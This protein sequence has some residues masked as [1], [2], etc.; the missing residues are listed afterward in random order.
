V[1][2]RDNAG[3][4]GAGEVPGGNA[5]QQTLEDARPL[6]MGRSIA[7]CNDVLNAIRK[8]FSSRDVGGRGQQTF[9]VRPTVHALPAG[10]AALFDLLGQAAGVPLAVLL[11]EG[12]RRGAVRMLGYL[13]YVGDRK[14]TSLAYRSATNANDDW[15]R[16]RDEEALTPATVVRLA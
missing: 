8:E 7:S 1:I 5:I 15:L 10:E 16:L 3:N 12:Q 13:F 2:L 6:V 9:D 14:R 4:T 11:G